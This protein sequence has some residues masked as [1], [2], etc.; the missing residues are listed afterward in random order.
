MEEPL[1]YQ[2]DKK[3]ELKEVFD[4]V[5]D[6]RFSLLCEMAEINYVFRTTQKKDDEG[7]MVLGEARKLSNRERDLYGYDFEICV[8][9]KSWKQLNEKQKVRLAWHELNHCVVKVDREGVGKYDKAGRVE[10][11]IRPHDIVLKTFME[12]IEIFGPSEAEESV[13]K[14]ISK[15]AGK[16][17]K[18]LKR[19]K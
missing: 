8:H 13:I 14:R 7:R 2:K 12:E 16:K 18:K 19:R 6:E 4:A 1:K 10:I 5:K 9:K 17:V 15:Y 3:G 11:G